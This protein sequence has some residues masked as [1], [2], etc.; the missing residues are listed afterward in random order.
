MNVDL[1]IPLHNVLTALPSLD[2]LPAYSTKIQA[3]LKSNK[4][5][6]KYISPAFQKNDDI[7]YTMHNLLLSKYFKE[8]ALIRINLT[9]LQIFAPL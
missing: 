4:D 7:L 2:E 3:L 1:P 9:L 6:I 5:D 8:K